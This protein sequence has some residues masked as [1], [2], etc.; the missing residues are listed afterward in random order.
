MTWKQSSDTLPQLRPPFC[1]E[2]PTDCSFEMKSYPAE[3]TVQNEDTNINYL[4]FCQS[5]HAR[6]TSTLFHDIMRCDRYVEDFVN[7]RI[8]GFTGMPILTYK[9]TTHE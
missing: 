7:D 8:C 2:S 1:D 9:K 6:I 5:G 3:A 4:I